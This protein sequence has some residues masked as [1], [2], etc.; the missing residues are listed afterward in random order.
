MKLRPY[1]NII[2]YKLLI[3][4]WFHFAAW[5]PRSLWISVSYICGDPSP[6]TLQANMKLFFILCCCWLEFPVKSLTASGQSFYQLS[7]RAMG[8]VFTMQSAVL[9]DFHHLLT[10]I[11]VLPC[12]FRYCSRFS[13]CNVSRMLWWFPGWVAAGMKWWCW[14]NTVLGYTDMHDQGCVDVQGQCQGQEDWKSR[15]WDFRYSFHTSW[16]SRCP[17]HNWVAAILVF[18]LCKRWIIMTYAK[19]FCMWWN[20]GLI[21]SSDCVFIFLDGTH[22]WFLYTKMTFTGSSTYSHVSLHHATTFPCW[23]ITFFH[24]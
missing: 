5:E 16:P 1:G 8:F 2:V 9:H 15:L 21:A 23:C 6:G 24:P 18:H 7:L 19:S 17:R 14:T 22:H 10:L 11:S 3:H 4:K 12:V 13:E 20:T